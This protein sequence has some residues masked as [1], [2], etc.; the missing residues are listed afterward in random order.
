MSLG[1]WWLEVWDAIVT[2]TKKVSEL[3][4]TT[5][6]GE[7]EPPLESPSAY[8]CP[9]VMP[10]EAATFTE[11]FYHPTFEIGIMVKDSDLKAGLRT[12]MTLA[13]KVA[14][15]LLDDRKLGGKVDALT[16]AFQPHWR[17]KVEFE[18]HWVGVL[19]T[20]TKKR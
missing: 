3:T 19:V 10:A 13:G 17:G 20:C 8:V 9:G 11:F 7:K 6:Y 4:D 14:D 15:E 5:F 1:D 12:A 2:E 16:V 18:R